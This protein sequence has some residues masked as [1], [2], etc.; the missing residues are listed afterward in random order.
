MNHHKIYLQYPWKF[1]DSP[2]YKSLIENPP[3]N[4]TYL[5]AEKAKEGTTSSLYKFLFSNFVKKNIRFILRILNNHSPNAHLTKSDEEYNLIHCAHCLSKNKDKP[6]VADMEGLF[7]MQ[8]ADI[9]TKKGNENIRKLLLRNNCKK[10]M[11]WTNI[12]KQNI[13]K[14]FPEIEDKIEVVYPA[15][16]EVKDLNKPKNKR[17]KIIYVA[18]YFH[19]KGGKIAL[20]ILEDLRKKYNIEG[21]VVSDTPENL[22]K[23]YSN[24][25]FYNLIPQK[26]LFELM[27][28]SDIFLYPSPVDTFG[29]SLL[30]SM[31]FGLPIVTLNALQTECRKEIIEDYKTGFIVEGKDIPKLTY[32]C[33]LLIENKELRKRMSHHCLMEIK[34]GKFSIK[35]RNEK[36]KRIYQEAIQ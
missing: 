34:E 21:I 32:F 7:S 17:L 25:N 4:V 28:N 20:E 3:E 2:Y 15:I 30:E 33:S 6:W 16:P 35:E 22:K 23:E 1:P 9:P 5:N 24:L 12:V 27:K 36:L 29:F 8:I 13:L 19:L 26:E 11:P 18:R 14:I 10:I 31:S